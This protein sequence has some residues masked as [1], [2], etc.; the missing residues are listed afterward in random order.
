MPEFGMHQ[1]KTQLS[2]LVERALKGETI[3]I[4]RGNVPVVTLVPVP[5]K[6][7]GRRPDTFGGQFKLTAA[8]WEPLPPEGLGEYADDFREEERDL[9]NG[10]VVRYPKPPKKKAK[11]KATTRKRRDASS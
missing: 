7:S 3:V 2:Q 5:P 9:G 11:K 6:R 1:A 4:T 10:I 8:F